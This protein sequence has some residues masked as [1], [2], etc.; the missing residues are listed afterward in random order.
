MA[1]NIKISRGLINP[2]NPNDHQAK[3]VRLTLTPQ[4]IRKDKFDFT[5]GRFDQGYPFNDVYYFCNQN[6]TSVYKYGSSQ[7]TKNP[8]TGNTS[9]VNG[10][11][12]FSLCGSS[13]PTLCTTV[14][15]PPLS[16][17]P[18]S[19]LC[20]P[21]TE[22]IPQPEC[23]PLPIPLDLKNIVNGYAYYV[24]SPRSVPVPG[25]GNLPVTCWGG[26]GCCRTK[27]KP[28]II[29]SSGQTI[30]ANRNISMDNLPGLTPNINCSSSS[31]IPVPTFTPLSPFDRSDTFSFIVPDPS[32]LSTSEFYLECLE[33]YCHNGVTMVFLVGE[34]LSGDPVLLFAGC[35]TPT[36]EGAKPIG[37]TDCDTESEPVLCN[38]PPP[39][40]PPPTPTSPTQPPC[41][42]LSEVSS[43][44]V[45]MPSFFYWA[46]LYSN[47]DYT[48]YIDSINNWIQSAHNIPITSGLVRGGELVEQI[49]YG[50]PG[51]YLIGQIV[52]TYFATNDA[53][54]VSITITNPNIVGPQ[55][56][57]YSGTTGY[58][59]GGG[60][61]LNECEFI[62]NSTQ[63][64]GQGL[65]NNTTTGPVVVTT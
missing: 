36:I 13:N 35:V 10:L 44:N 7:Y 57:V 56:L 3:S 53:L 41:T 23:T 42:P 29:T 46:D 65:F 24:N 38:P 25:F 54:I 62:L 15:T 59:Y 2:V 20:V 21:P 6:L 11:N 43:V 33:N 16:L 63:D 28:K 19:C 30:V 60:N 22:C 58:V 32:V 50:S 39:P 64:G 14:C 34:T 48:A 26:H 12:S 9:L 55:Y 61:Y 47:P 8:F 18:V 4:A 1:N 31:Q 5:T 45:S 37:T 51:N 49:P 52:F 17:D 27:F 40:P